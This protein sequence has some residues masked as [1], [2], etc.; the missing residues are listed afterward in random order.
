MIDLTT[1]PSTSA[2]YVPYTR[3]FPCNPPHK[4]FPP[5]HRVLRISKRPEPVHRCSQFIVRP[6]RTIELQLAT[7]SYS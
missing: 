7:S 5:G 1:Q 4:A 2:L 6:A 3:E